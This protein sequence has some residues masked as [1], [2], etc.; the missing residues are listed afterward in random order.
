MR[1]S[2][3]PTD[4]ESCSTTSKDAARSGEAGHFGISAPRVVD[5]VGGVVL[6]IIAGLKLSAAIVM[7]IGSARVLLHPADSENRDLHASE[8]S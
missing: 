3:S 1:A 8:K 4:T 7:L 6:L 2:G 5:I